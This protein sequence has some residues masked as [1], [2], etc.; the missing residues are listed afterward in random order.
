M[1]DNSKN[2]S[3]FMTTRRRKLVDQAL[4]Q[5]YLFLRPSAGDE[6][7]SGFLDWENEPFSSEL[8][9]WAYAEECRR[10]GLPRCEIKWFG[11]S[12]TAHIDVSTMGCTEISQAV[13]RRVG[14]FVF[15]FADR[16]HSF[17]SPLDNARVV[18]FRS[19]RR[20]KRMRL[21][22][23]DTKLWVDLVPPAYAAE[24]IL[25]LREI[26]LEVMTP[27]DLLWLL[28]GVALDAGD[29]GSRNGD[30]CQCLTMGSASKGPAGGWREC[31]MDAM[32]S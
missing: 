8:V 9:S 25:G 31:K 17:A 20:L 2:G 22:G 11:R 26:V 3:P 24:I 10:L 4:V 32:K 28:G 7:W 23:T 16:L 15:G 21:T 18:S 6:H 27:C 29:F 12:V 30:R 14:D 13:W 1:I 19:Q 5:G